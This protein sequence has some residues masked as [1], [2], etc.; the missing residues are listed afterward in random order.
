MR[1]YKEEGLKSTVSTAAALT[2]TLTFMG[3]LV[4]QLKQYL[5]GKTPYKNNNEFYVQAIQQGGGLGIVT[6]LFMLAG[7]QNI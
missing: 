4:L 1:M 2:A 7:G 6:D 5:A 3:G